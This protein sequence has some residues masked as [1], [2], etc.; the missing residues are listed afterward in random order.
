MGS[1]RCDAAQ[2][3]ILMFN[4]RQ[5]LIGIVIC[6]IFLYACSLSPA[7]IE[8]GSLTKRTRPEVSS[9]GLVQQIH[10][11][12]NTERKSH[13]L[14]QVEWDDDLAVIGRIH[15]ADMARRHFLPIFPRKGGT[16]YS[17]IV[18]RDINAPYGR[19]QLSIWMPRTEPSTSTLVPLPRLS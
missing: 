18:S 11:L 7:Q 4:Y 3:M 12:I 19:T 10:A 15:S 1:D 9:A 14:M 13:G 5:K 8:P 6:A 16:S 17:D 2:N